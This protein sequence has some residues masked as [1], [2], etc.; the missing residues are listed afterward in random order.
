[1]CLAGPL[2][3]QPS[4]PPF[5]KQFYLSFMRYSG[6]YLWLEQGSGQSR[7]SCPAA[8][9]IQVGD[10]CSSA[11]GS[12][13]RFCFC[14]Y[15]INFRQTKYHIIL[16]EWTNRVIRRANLILIRIIGGARGTANS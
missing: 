3:V 14:T 2:Q 13:T 5:P 6:D 11:P 1:M 9:S 7:Q 12:A 8:D 16:L 4:M 10:R 15:Q